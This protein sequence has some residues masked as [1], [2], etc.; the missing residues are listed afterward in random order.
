[1]T[2]LQALCLSQPKLHERTNQENCVTITLTCE[3]N[4]LKNHTFS[5]LII[6]TSFILCFTNPFKYL[7][8]RKV[9]VIL[10][11]PWK[12]VVSHF[13]DIGWELKKTPGDG[14]CFISSI[15]QCMESDHNIVLD[16]CEVQ[17][18][19]IDQGIENSEQYSNYHFNRTLNKQ[20]TNIT[21]Y[22]FLYVWTHGLFWE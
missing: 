9:P 18:L 15:A 20:Q 14:F 3:F 17:D 22:W 19:I 6:L 13:N 5:L 4:T 7:F 10:P 21:Q 1:M 12:D 16:K 2:L 11:I 8:Y